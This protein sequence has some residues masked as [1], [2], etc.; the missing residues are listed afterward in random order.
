MSRGGKHLQIYLIYGL[1]KLTFTQQIK[2]ASRCLLETK[3]IRYVINEFAFVYY[4]VLAN[5]EGKFRFTSL[6][7]SLHRNIFSRMLFMWAVNHIIFRIDMYEGMPHPNHLIF[8]ESERVVSKKEGIDFAREYGCLFTECSAKTRA[9]VEQCFEELVLKVHMQL[10]PLPNK[11]PHTYTVMQTHKSQL[12]LIPESWYL[13]LW[14]IIAAITFVSHINVYV[15]LY[16]HAFVL[17]NVLRG[18]TFKQWNESVTRKLCLDEWKSFV[19]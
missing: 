10:S 6:V 18:F 19:M 16:W 2:I 12:H 13:R 3:L 7:K 4:F 11:K 8:Q 9:N 17:W 1:K 5:F 15:L 14:V